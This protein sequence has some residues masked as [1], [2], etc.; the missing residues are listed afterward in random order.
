M[1]WM[2]IRLFLR[3][4]CQEVPGRENPFLASKSSA[5]IEIVL[6][7]DGNANTAGAGN[8]LGAVEVS[9]YRIHG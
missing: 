9:C 1:S 5:D 2:A 3:L 7:I 6:P 4:A 8:S